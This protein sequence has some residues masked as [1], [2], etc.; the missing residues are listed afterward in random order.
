MYFLW[1]KARR[2]GCRFL[3]FVQ[4]MDILTTLKSDPGYSIESYM[5]F[6]Q[7]NSTGSDALIFEELQHSMSYIQLNKKI[8]NYFSELETAM[9]WIIITGPLNKEFIPALSVMFALAECSDHIQV[10][11]LLKSE[12]NSGA[13][14]D[15]KE[16]SELPAPVLIGKIRSDIQKRF[17]WYSNPVKKHTLQ[18]EQ[19][20]LIQQEIFDHTRKLLTSN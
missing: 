8:Y 6:L 18:E 5:D 17:I 19:L 4:S 3:T 12:V 7:E 9:E 14:N 10:R 20:S 1:I 15:Y 16:E 2:Q 11:I 13:L